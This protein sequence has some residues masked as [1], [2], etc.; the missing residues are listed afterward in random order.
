MTIKYGGFWRRLCAGVVDAFILSII[1][2][3]CALILGLFHYSDTNPDAVY[4][5]VGWVSL[6]VVL[7]PWIYYAWFHSSRY[8]A[9]LGMLLFKMKIYTYAGTR[10]S[11]G[12]AT[13]R[14]LA[15]Y[16][17]SGWLTLGIGYLMIAFTQRKQALHD[18]IAHT[19]VVV[20]PPP[21]ITIEAALRKAG[22]HN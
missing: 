4:K 6:F 16:F 5:A 11:F 20:S 14:Y 8:Q 13:G 10:I 1:I 9:T 21:A 22:H 2:S 18:F 15:A 12:R 17:L 19:L 3:V 7:I